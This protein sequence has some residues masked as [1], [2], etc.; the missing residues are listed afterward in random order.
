MAILLVTVEMLV[1][2]KLI[3]FPVNGKYDV[4]Y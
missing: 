4:F 3:Q 1:E 2:G